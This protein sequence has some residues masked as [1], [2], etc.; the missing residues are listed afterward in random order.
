MLAQ[1]LN[2]FHREIGEFVKDAVFWI[3]YAFDHI[4]TD[5]ADVSLLQAF[6]V[7]AQIVQGYTSGE[8]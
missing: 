8:D 2:T 6:D 3:A 5:T 1:L 4:A 7:L